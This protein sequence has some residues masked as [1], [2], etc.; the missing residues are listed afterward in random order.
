MLVS[1]QAVAVET[2]Q[3]SAFFLSHSIKLHIFIA[4]CYTVISQLSCRMLDK[5]HNISVPYFSFFLSMQS[6]KVFEKNVNGCI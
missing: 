3:S 6:T 1:Y 5:L 2:I 4:S